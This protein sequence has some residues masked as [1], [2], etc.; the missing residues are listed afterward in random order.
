MTLSTILAAIKRALSQPDDMVMDHVPVI[1]PKK[2]RDWRERALLKAAAKYG[3]PFK[4]AAKGL[5]REVMVTPDV[6]AN[7]KG[8]EPLPGK[9]LA[10]VTKIKAAK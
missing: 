10:K 8:G 2:K 9:P 3:K 1:P 6:F 7:V 4:C 5:D